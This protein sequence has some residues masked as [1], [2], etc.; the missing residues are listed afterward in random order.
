MEGH[1]DGGSPGPQRAEPLWPCS[2][3]NCTRPR[4]DF[5]NLGRSSYC[6]ICLYQEWDAEAPAIV[7]RKKPEAG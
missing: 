5:G 2:K 3:A 1:L 7:Q 6:K 4:H